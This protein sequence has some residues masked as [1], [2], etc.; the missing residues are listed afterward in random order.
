MALVQAAAPSLLRF[1]T[2]GSVD[3]GKSTLIGRL[4]YDSKSVFEDQLGA[5][6]KDSKKFGTQGENL[7]LALLVDGLAAER[8]QGITIDVAYRYFSTPRRSFI[9][10]DTPGHEQYTRNM[11]TGASTADLAV[12]L[13]DARKGILPQTRRHSFIVSML[14]VRRVALAVNKMDLVGYAQNVFDRIVAEYKAAAAGLG[15]ASI[16]AF[17]ISARDGDNVTTPSAN[18]PWYKGAALLDYLETVDVSAGSAADGP[19][20]LPVQ[21]VNRPNLDFRGF[22]GTIVSGV[23]RKGDEIVAQPS[24]RRSRVARIV[25]QDGDLDEAG[26]EQAI[27]LTL[28]DEVDVSRGDVIVAANDRIAPRRQFHARLIWMV[29]QP[30]AAGREYVVKLAT[31]SANAT[32]A[33]LHHAIDIHSFAPKQAGELRMNEIGLVTLSFDKP[34][35][36]TDYAE[37]RDLGGF[38]LID[39]F[40]N[41]TAGIGM[42]DGRADVRAGQAP[43]ADETVSQRIERWR[44]GF[45]RRRGE[46]GSLRR[47]SFNKAASWRLASTMLIFA[48]AL[49]ATANIGPA[50]T[51]TII[52]LVA[53]PLLRAAHERFWKKSAP[54]P[55]GLDSGAG[56]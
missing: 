31:A 8:E 24:G 52:D 13:I 56:I 48:A 3:D 44:I 5:L 16:E 7:D 49:L 45:A 2:C 18:M 54:D 43:V 50:L 28:A 4:L 32:V 9:V 41:M 42:I 53:R 39:K 12:I 1:F 11:A 37:N 34:L 6:D 51:I 26:A 29:E 46:P 21:W 20:R 10:A 23:I 22:A 15:F 25:T 27:T 38:I 17:P 33:A 40:T 55:D 35:V 47:H 30:I 14:R 19:F 36:A